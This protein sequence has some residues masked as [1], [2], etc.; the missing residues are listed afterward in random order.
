MV[1]PAKQRKSYE[2]LIIDPYRTLIQ[3]SD[4]IIKKA[5]SFLVIGFGFNDD[6]LTPKLILKLK[7]ALL[8]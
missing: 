3:K 8:L 5:N 4:D 7:K 1:L 2:A 6:H